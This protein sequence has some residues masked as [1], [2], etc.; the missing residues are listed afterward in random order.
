VWLISQA[1]SGVEMALWDIAGKLAERPVHELLGGAAQ[2]VRVYAGGNFLSQGTAAVH[3]E[4]FEPFLAKGVTAA[5]V[6]LGAS[7]EAELA[8]LAELRRLFGPNVAIFIDGNEAFRPT[9]AA[10]IAP[11]L[12]ECGVRFF[13]EPCPRDDAH[14]LARFVAASPVPIA[15]GEHVFGMAGFVELAD[16]G[17]ANVW[18]PDAAVCG[19]IAELRKIAAAAA[20]RN[21]PLSPHS[22]GTPIGLAANLHAATGAPTLTWLEM[23]AR[24]DDLVPGFTGGEAVSTRSIKNGTLVPPNAPGIGVEPAPD[25]AERYPYRVPPP[26]LSAPALYQ[27]S[28]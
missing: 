16:D 21:V 5:K 13:E 2:P 11:R 23:S 10:R 20:E 22:A 25:L 28:V 18:Q 8:T 3:R 27:G 17:V 14:A 9:T 26:L 1:L 15:Y 24:I 6:R 4:H 12:A 19:G 7:W